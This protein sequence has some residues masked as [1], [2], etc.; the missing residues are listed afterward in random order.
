MARSQTSFNKKEKEI[1][2]KVIEKSI[3]AIEMM[4]GQGLEKT[5]NK[6]NKN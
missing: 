5:M 1:I 2:E 3:E 6:Y 4:L